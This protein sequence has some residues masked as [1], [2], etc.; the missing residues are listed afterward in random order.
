MRWKILHAVLALIIG[1]STLIMAADRQRPKTPDARK[2]GPLHQLNLAH[3]LPADCFLYI[4]FRD[5]AGQI[6]AWQNSSLQARY[7][8]SK[9][10]ELWSRRHLSLKL[11]QRLQ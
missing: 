1:V 4:Q 5:L 11:S 9:S 6:K 7:Y 10:F 8:E 3:Y 2:A